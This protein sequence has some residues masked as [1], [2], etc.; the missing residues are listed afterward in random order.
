LVIVAVVVLLFLGS[1]AT[2][3]L[4]TMPPDVDPQTIPSQVLEPPSV[5]YQSAVE[6]GR[7]V[8]RSLLADEKLPGLSLAVAVDGGVVWAEGFR[9]A[10]M[11]QQSPMT[12]ATILR[13]GGV[14]ASLTASAVGR[15]LDRGRLDL[16]APVQSILPSF[17]AQQ[18]PISLRQLMSHTAGLRPSRGEAG[19][20]RGGHCSSDAD[21][22]AVFAQDSLRTRPGTEVH[23]STQD[24][25]L[26][27]AMV[28]AAAHEPYVEFM[29]RDLFTPLGMTSTHPD[30]AG[31]TQPGSA[32]FYY[33]RMML[34]PSYGL[35]DAPPVDLSC[36]LPAVGYLSTPSDL[37]RLGAALMGDS[38]I[39]AETIAA[40]QTPVRLAS[41][42][43]TEQALGW[44][45]RN[46]PMGAGATPTRIVGQGL[47][48]PVVRKP[49]SATTVGGQ[50]SGGTAAL[51][52]VPEH[53][54]AIAVATNVT[55]SEKVP[56][57]SVRLAE[58]FVDFL[59]RP[60]RED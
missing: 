45:V 50:V 59:T 23:Y 49:L 33:P 38:L 48:E 11:Q 24:W 42:E 6:Q 22:L 39:S 25:V 58:V 4:V 34:N 44:T 36:T 54:I 46:V 30:V 56:L 60:S 32:H 18:W 26:V 27:G 3:V 21:R 14:S 40:L 17:P 35:Q 7:S 52:L 16:D 29:R 13:I 51:V 15:L 10:D 5:A 9:W 31:Q 12:P 8:T 53:R 57:L 1:V 37:V 28:A 47:G 2:Y 43:A 19:I 55:G 41:G 20:F